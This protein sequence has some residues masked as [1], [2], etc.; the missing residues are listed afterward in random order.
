M[1]IAKIRRVQKY[2]N[3]CNDIDCFGCTSEVYYDKYL[4]VFVLCDNYR[5]SERTKGDWLTLSNKICDW[6]FDEFQECYCVGN[7]LR[8]P[9]RVLVRDFIKSSKVRSQKSLYES[10]EVFLNSNNVDC[11]KF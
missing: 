8:E 7:N 1:S 4:E 11:Y 2:L 10:L 3:P 6:V 9:V 5:E